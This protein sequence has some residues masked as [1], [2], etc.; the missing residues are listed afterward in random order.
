MLTFHMTFYLGFT[1]EGSFTNVACGVFQLKVNP[2]NMVFKSRS[3]TESLS[4][5]PS[6]SCV[7][8][9]YGGPAIVSVLQCSCI[10]YMEICR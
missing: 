10:H 6:V 1:V 7:Q 9:L 3:V 8:T 2:S 5:N 4:Q